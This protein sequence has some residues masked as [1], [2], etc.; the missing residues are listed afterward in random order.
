MFIKTALEVSFIKSPKLTEFNRFR[1]ETLCDFSSS[2]HKNSWDSPLQLNRRHDSLLNVVTTSELINFPRSCCLLPAAR[3]FNIE[4]PIR[5]YQR[6]SPSMNS[7]PSSL[8]IDIFMTCMCTRWTAEFSIH[9]Y[10]QHD[11][12][13][14]LL[15]EMTKLCKLLVI[16]AVPLSLA[17]TDSVTIMRPNFAILVGIMIKI[18]AHFGGK[19]YFVG[20]QDT[21]CSLFN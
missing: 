20:A 13:H 10:S 17:A 9:H 19:C 11:P 8:A 4:D 12:F 16:A 18:L 14:N 1:Y 6:R 5:S 15:I 21:V 2:R 7:F 3:H